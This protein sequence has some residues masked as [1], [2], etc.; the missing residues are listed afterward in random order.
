MFEGLKNMGAMA[1]MMK[2]LPRMQARMQEVRDGLSEIRVSACSSNGQVEVIAGGD[3]QIHNVQLA[4]AALAQ[5]QV[6]VQES[7][8]EAV[9]A[10]LAA[11]QAEAQ[12]RLAQVAQELGLPV[13]PQGQLPGLEG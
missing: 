6:Q 10:A 5:D 9:N 4:D 12:A 13:G 7:V 2:D 1:S 8:R 3:L 11:A